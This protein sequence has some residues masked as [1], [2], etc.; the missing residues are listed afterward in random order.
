MTTEIS[1]IPHWVA[2]PTFANAMAMAITLH[3]DHARKADREPYLGHLLGVASNVIEAGGTEDQAA[4]ALLH[5]AIEDR[6]STP[7][8]IEKATNVLVAWIVDACS[9]ERTGRDDD[10]TETWALRKQT[11]L[12]H[13]AEATEEDP[14]LLVALADK[15]NNCEKTARDLRRHLD[16]DGKSLESFWKAFNSGDSCQEWWY[17]GLLRG[18]STKPQ[19]NTRL[20]QPL[21]LRLERAI[22]DLFGERAIIPC[23]KGHQHAPNHPGAK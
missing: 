13:L 14:S 15:V 1:K 6:Q 21:L 12:T 23:D 16:Q 20:A 11:Y 22:E 17:R 19:L 4:A 7:L 3:A 18:F 10:G 2:G 8:E 9:E 5:D